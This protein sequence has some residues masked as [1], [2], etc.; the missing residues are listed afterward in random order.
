M[1]KEIRQPL[2]MLYCDKCGVPYTNIEGRVAYIS[3]KYL[4]ED[5]EFDGWADIDG[6]HYC[7]DCY[8]KNEHGENVVDD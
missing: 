8:H 4:L 7:P 6:K 1:I 2:Y 5:A 3:D